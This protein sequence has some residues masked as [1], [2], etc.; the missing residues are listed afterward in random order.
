MEEMAEAMGGLG[1]LGDSSEPED[2][3]LGHRQ[4][5]RGKTRR[6]CSIR[7][8]SHKRPM[9][10]EHESGSALMGQIRPRQ[11]LV[12]RQIQVQVQTTLPCR[13]TRGFLHS[14]LLWQ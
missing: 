1:S 14:F 12:L 7:K 5:L 2:R 10:C 8:P 4:H 13:G 6:N 9:Y 11:L 3:S